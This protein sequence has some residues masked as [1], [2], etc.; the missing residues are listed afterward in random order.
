MTPLVKSIAVGAVALFGMAAGAQ[1]QTAYVGLTY[2][3][4]VPQV[5]ATHQKLS[6]MAGALFGFGITSYGGEIEFSVADTAGTESTSRLRGMVH[7]DLGALG[8]FATLG[9]SDYGLEGGGKA[10]GVNYGLG[11]DYAVTDRIDV[12]LEAL[13]DVLWGASNVTS[14]RA[15]VSYGF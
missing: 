11:V 10:N 3:N 8:T 9:L 2:G 14:I 4:A 7:Y 13:R 1:A 15:G 6:V 5:G 12:R